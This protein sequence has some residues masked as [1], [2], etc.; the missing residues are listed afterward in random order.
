MKTEKQLYNEISNLVKIGFLN[1]GRYKYLSYT[2]KDSIQ[3]DE[4]IKI[5]C[6]GKYKNKQLEI[7]STNKRIIMVNTGIMPERNEISIEKIDS[8]QLESKGLFIALHI[9]VGSTK[10]IIENLSN[11]Q[12]FM[13]VV[14]EQM[15]NYKSFKIEINKTVE[16]DVTDKIEK[17]AELHKEG[18]L[19]EYEFATK[20]MELLESLKK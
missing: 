3:D 7:L 20:K 1:N 15:N 17:L 14:N 2:L 18:I 4:D 19:T 16:K 11:Y 10:F 8:M 12:E 6:S 5:I 9:N 13:N